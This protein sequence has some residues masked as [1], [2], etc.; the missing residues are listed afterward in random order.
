[1]KQEKVISL[2]LGQRVSKSALAVAVAA[3]FAAPEHVRRSMHVQVPQMFLDGQHQ[4]SDSQALTATALST[5]VV[6]L[7]QDRSIGNGEP[8][9]VMFNVEVA[10]D[11]TTGDEDYQFDVEYASDA[12]LTTARKLIGR[13][14]FES[15]TPGAPAEDADLL[16]AGFKFIIPI[17]PA[18]LSE[19]E[20]FLGVRYTLAGTT[21]TITV[22]AYLMPMSMIE[23]G[24]VSFPKG[25]TIS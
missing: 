2:S 4:Y 12:G 8:M 16:V 3:A 23:V 24:Q 14:I 17:P 25:Y 11:Q 10:A 6:D 15:G 19:S 22:S 18:A 9:C 1:M 7:S 20:R 21:P 13:R 5:N